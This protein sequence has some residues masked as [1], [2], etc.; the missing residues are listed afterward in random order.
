M[1]VHQ[2]LKD[3]Q[4]NNI[5]LKSIISALRSKPLFILLLLSI[6]S[7]PL[8]AHPHNWITLKSEFLINEKGEL[9]VVRSHWEFDIYFS[10]MTIAA[11][12][13]E[14]T[15][16][17]NSLEILGDD[18]INN[19]ESY[20]YFSLLKINNKSVPLGRPQP[21]ELNIVP[22]KEQQ[23]QLVLSMD[24]K[25]DKPIPLNNKEVSWQVFDPTYFIDMRHQDAS[26]ITISNAQGI[27]CKKRIV[28]PEPTDDMIDYAMSLDRSQTETQGL[29]ES[30]AEKVVIQCNAPTLSVAP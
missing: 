5:K 16:Q 14:E 12:M 24:F 22:N 26:K 6:S 4:M 9:T 8:S 7:S 17:P 23:Q 2:P 27:E 20:R 30:F 13:N 25:F 19:M 29:G 3:K 11:V 28:L 21:Y 10:M 1:N 15:V 18:M